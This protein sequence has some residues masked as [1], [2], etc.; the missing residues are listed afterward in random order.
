MQH[1]K[2]AIENEL[3]ANET[4]LDADYEA[5]LSSP[6]DRARV[7]H[8]LHEGIKI[9][10]AIT[11]LRPVGEVFAYWRDFNN[12]PNFMNNLVSVEVRSPLRSHWVWK[13]VADLTFEWEMEVIAEIQDRMISWQTLPG[14]EMNHAGSVWLRPAPQD[15]ATVIHVQ[16][17]YAPPVGRLGMKLA[18]LLGEDPAK[19]VTEALR[20]LRSIL[21]AG[22]VPTTEGQP[23]GSRG[24]LH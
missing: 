8:E 17:R 7:A 14:S 3:S 24:L 15:E 23:H 19:S 1:D 5:D 13:T 6:S 9:E 22:E 12:L 2:R 21:E 11:V 10:K 16:L 20:R 4:N 18:E